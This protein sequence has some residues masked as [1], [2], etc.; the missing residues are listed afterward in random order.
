MIIRFLLVLLF[1]LPSVSF[2]AAPP[3]SVSLDNVKFSD[4]ARVVYG[5]ILNLSYVF[6]S[7][8]IHSGDDLTVNWR[9]LSLPQI[10]ALTS[11]IF[12]THGYDLSNEGGILRI[13]KTKREDQELFIYSVRFRSA[14]Y[15]SD[16]VAKVAGVSQLGVRGL[17]GS[18]G[19]Q[20]SVEKMPEAV[21]A[22]SSVVDR[23]ALDQIAYSCA[24]A[25]CARLKKLLV[26][27][28]MPEPQIVLRAAVY[29][30]GTSAGKASA[31]QIATGLLGGRLNLTAG[32]SLSGATSSAH[33]IDGGLDA[34]LSVL[35]NDSRFKIV[36]R[37]MLRVRTGSQGKFSVGQN[38]PVLGAI[39][40]DKN[41]NP[42]QSV[43]YKQSG[44]IFTVQ[45]DV[46]ADVIDLNVTQELSSFVKT[47][48]GVNNSPTLLQRTA[49]SQLS[50]K[51][52]EVV[53]FAG[54]EDHR[55]D[56]SESTLFGLPLSHN[57]NDSSSEVLV[58]IEAQRI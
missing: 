9:N 16:I 34:V 22:A 32:S 45:P 29:E 19:F 17:P 54:L 8:F 52:D 55:Q 11:E 18:A 28:D 37:P 40:F 20:S 27:L 47:T 6:D 33:Y 42:V 24:P 38:V 51:S 12:T 25:E 53:V 48:T 57:A 31:L 39:S 44:T 46:R 4:L 14:R 1:L 49:T 58:F 56:D 36:S 7:D 35:D 3:I 41:G 13:R 5:D 15:L 30:V 23:S 21:G 26:D 50:I 2:S 43:D 10:K